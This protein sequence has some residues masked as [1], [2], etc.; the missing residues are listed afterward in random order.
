MCG[1]SRSVSIVCAYL[2]F[3]YNIKP[4]EALKM[5]KTIRPV[6]NPNSSFLQQLENY[7]SSLDQVPETN[8]IHEPI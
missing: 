2:S 7:Y 3:K 4:V 6:A 5:I 1:V 8:D